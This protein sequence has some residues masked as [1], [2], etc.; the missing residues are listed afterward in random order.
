MITNVKDV[1]KIKTSY[2]AG[3]GVIWCSYLENYLIVLQKV[4]YRLAIWYSNCTSKE[5]HIKHVYGE[6]PGSLVVKIWCFHLCALGLETEIPHQAAVH[7][8]Q[9]KRKEKK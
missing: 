5:V 3:R 1:E 9:K 4:N 8:S 7:H 6:L 2:T